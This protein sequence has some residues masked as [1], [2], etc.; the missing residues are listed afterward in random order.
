MSIPFFVRKGMVYHQS[1]A[2]AVNYGMPSY[3]DSTMAYTLYR[4]LP[5]PERE[6]DGA[7]L[8]GTGLAINPYNFLLTDAAQAAAR[9]PQE[10]IRFWRTFQAA[11]KAAGG[12]PGCPIDGLYGKTVRN[13]MF[14][15]IAKLPVPKSKQA[16]DEVYAFLQSEKCDV[17]SA[18]I[19]YRL[20]MEGL[21]AV[22]S[23]TESDY[24]NHLRSVKARPSRENDTAC[25]TMAATIKAAAACVRNAKQRRQWALTLW[26]LAKG[27]EMYFGHR[28]R[29]ST[30][31]T[32]P[33]LA[34]LAG[35][36]MLKGPQ[37]MQPFLDRITAEL[38]DSVSGERNIKN[39]RLLAARIGAA[40][41]HAKDADQK[42]EWIEGLSRIIA[43]HE[44]F[45]P[46]NAGKKAKAVRDPCT[47]VIK[48]L[49]ESP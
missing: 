24:K 46:R 33:L 31:P 34:R 10:Q 27:H 29:V 40:G 11:L 2:W 5:G 1:I 22:L 18:L 6:A 39:C 25:A 35:Q 30:D 9:T 48:A 28:L 16:V 15:R 20:A 41:K 47:N 36:R 49:L 32:V 19:V 4:L 8:L 17:P 38:K 26:K 3:L 12:K 42:R 21:P 23:S 44:T 45:K 13:R 7:T 37:L 14:A 43:G